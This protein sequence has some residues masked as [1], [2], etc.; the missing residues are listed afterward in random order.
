MSVKN[1]ELTSFDHALN[2]SLMMAQVALRH[3]DRVGLLA[4]D[5]EVRAWLAPKGGA[6]SGARLIRGTYDLEPSLKE[7]DY[8]MALQYL[9]G[10]VRR[11]SLVVLLTAVSDG[12][13][14]DFVESMMATLSNRHLPLCVWLRDMSIEHLVTGPRPTHLDHYVGGAAA[15]WLAWRES[16]LAKL[17]SRGVLVVDSNPDGLTPALLSRYLEVKARRLL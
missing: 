11:R 1:G 9:A 10:R 4:F 16:V 14:G 17:Q 7:P 2:A 8:G 6:R 5:S 12:M 15:E 13:S 3:G